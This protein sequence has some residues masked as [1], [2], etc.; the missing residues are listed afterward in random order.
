MKM[1]ITRMPKDEEQQ[2]TLSAYMGQI[3]AT[4]KEKRTKEKKITYPFYILIGEYY[5]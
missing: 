1:V 2:S 4:T 5:Y 3:F